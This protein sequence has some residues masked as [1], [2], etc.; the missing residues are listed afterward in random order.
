MSG[1]VRSIKNAFNPPDPVT[2]RISTPTEQPK[3][4]TSRENEARKKSLSRARRRQ[5]RQSTI[6]SSEGG[7][8][9]GA[10]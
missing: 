10:A 5:G 4:D 9:L 8:K 2:P 1:I 7:G 3:R 6:L